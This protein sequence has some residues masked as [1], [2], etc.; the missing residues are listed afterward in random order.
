[1]SHV[2]RFLTEGA[3]SPLAE[4]SEGL[5]AL[6]DP[7]TADLSVVGAAEGWKLVA[8]ARWKPRRI[9]PNPWAAVGFT[10]DDSLMILNL[11]RVD[12]TA[13]PAAT[14]RALELQAHQFCSTRAS[15]WARTTT[16]T[17]RHTHDG[18]FLVGARKTPMKQLLKTSE[19]IF[20]REREKSFGTLTPKQRN[21]AHLL[22]TA[23]G[24][25]S[26]AELI[27]RLQELTPDKRITK[28]AVHVELSRM[29]QNSMLSLVRDGTGNYIIGPNTDENSA[30]AS[31]MVG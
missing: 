9:Y 8:A 14:K 27:T 21:I 7:G 10:Q 3:P 31:E 16:H 6:L 5:Y 2:D 11:A 20:A 15:Q 23:E 24:G 12:H 30:H 29:R 18:Y 26:I 4:L 22:S 1:M 13:L 19:E 25:L 17:A 28:G